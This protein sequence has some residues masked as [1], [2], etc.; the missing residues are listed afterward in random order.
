MAYSDTEVID[1]KEREGME[2]RRDRG[3][4]VDVIV[5]KE[6][7]VM[8]TRQKLC[9]DMKPSKRVI[10]CISLDHQRQQ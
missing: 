3:K 4:K 5:G 8:E 1:G 9:G 6:A 10:T 2:R 7:E